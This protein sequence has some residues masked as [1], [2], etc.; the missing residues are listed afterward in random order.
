MAIEI[1]QISESTYQ[2]NGKTVFRD[3]N[4]KWISN[5]DLTDFEKEAFRNHI[6]TIE[7]L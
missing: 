2:I 5:S 4:E 3:M 1:K 6:R 7:A